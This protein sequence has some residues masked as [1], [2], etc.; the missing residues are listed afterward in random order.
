ME[1]TFFPLFV[2]LSKKNILIVGGGK[3]AVRRVK[4]LLLFTKKMKIV[5]PKAEEELIRLAKEQ[6]LTICL[7]EFEEK[8]L[9]GMDLVL[10]TTNDRDTNQMVVEHCREKGILVNTADCKEECDFYFPSIV[11]E[12]SV[13]IGINSSGTDPAKVKET[14]KKI[15]TLFL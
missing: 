2:D 15:E 1:H 14:R 5:T 11:K 13:V 4:T 7:R 10:A 9:E 12:D 6:D 3:I 8:D